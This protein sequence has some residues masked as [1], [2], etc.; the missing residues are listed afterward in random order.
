MKQ[1]KKRDRQGQ[2]TK[3]TVALCMGSNG[4]HVLTAELGAKENYEVRVITRSAK[5]FAGTITCTEKRPLFRS[6]PLLFPQKPPM[7]TTGKADM[8]VNWQNVGKA[9]EGV[10]IILLIGPVHCYR[11]TLEKV[12][13]ALPGSRGFPILIGTLFAQGGFDWLAYDIFKKYN[14]LNRLHEND[15][16]LFGLKRFPY[17]CKANKPGEH[18]FLHG[19]FEHLSAAVYP[20]TPKT[21]AAVTRE[22][23]SIFK[24]TPEILND[25]LLCTLNFS[26]QCL[27][28]AIL[29]GYFYDYKPGK[30]YHRAPHFYAESTPLSQEIYARLCWEI[31]GLRDVIQ[32]KLGIKLRK[33]FGWNPFLS[34]W[35]Q[36]FS[37]SGKKFRFKWI[38]MQTLK[39]WRYHQVLKPAKVPMM[40][41]NPKNPKGNELVPNVGS[42]FWTDDISHGLCVILGLRDLL[43]SD[44][45]E[46][47]MPTVIKM[48]QFHQHWL[49]KD[50]VGHKPDNPGRR[51]TGADVCETAAPQSYGIKSWN[52]FTEIAGF[53][54]S[55]KKFP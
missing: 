17:I 23:K 22:I 15:I 28:P 43:K 2:K 20:N 16:V 34:W 21:T 25:W 14:K 49:G 47:H 39:A 30:T 46:V 48:I 36:T 13:P 12:V 5:N 38:F 24:M 9:L 31:A 27:H 35:F 11:E 45:I 3:R 51:L 54:K 40:P 42:R 37:V 32:T 44:G 10:D 1:R 8:V 19:R 55:S 33:G 53:G 50:Y 4:T 6:F 41:A 29:Y 7:V 52:Q 18:V 26:N